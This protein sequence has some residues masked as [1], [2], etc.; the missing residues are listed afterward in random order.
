MKTKK[1]PDL[2]KS[3]TTVV[4]GLTGGIG[5][6]K[7]TVSRLFREM[8]AR[9][10]DADL[11][12]KEVVEPGRPAW[13]EIV[14]EFGRK[15]L[16]PDQSINRRSLADLVFSD[17]GALERLNGIVHPRVYRVMGLEIRKARS[18]RI[19]L[20]VLDIPLLFESPVPLRLDAVAVVYA[21]RE[22]Q[23]RR[24]RERDGFSRREARLRL[25]NQMPIREKKR[26]ADLVIDNR[27]NVDDT[28]RQVKE[29]VNR[30]WP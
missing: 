23:M 13:K 21:P 12:A 10:V 22:V 5:T 4:L 26:L 8:G 27:G 18:E 28:R 2:G 9:V 16:N 7:S 20:L 11:V 1:I 19:P 17:R 6:G 29:I 14:R 24:L 15:F 25:A 3:E 30:V